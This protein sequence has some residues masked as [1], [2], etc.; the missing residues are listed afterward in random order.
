MWNRT[1]SWSKKKQKQKRIKLAF[2]IGLPAN[3]AQFSKPTVAKND[4]FFLMLILV[5]INGKVN[6]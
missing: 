4:S 6:N 3:E 5:N 1:L 2:E